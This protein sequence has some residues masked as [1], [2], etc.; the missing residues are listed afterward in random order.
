MS[1]VS[2]FPCFGGYFSEDCFDTAVEPVIRGLSVFNIYIP[3]V[4]Q[5]V[6]DV[7]GGLHQ[8]CGQNPTPDSRWR[9]PLG[10][11]RSASRW[12]RLMRRMCTRRPSLMVDMRL[13][14]TLHFVFGFG[15]CRFEECAEV[16]IFEA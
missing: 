4:P 16:V 15:D 3:N 12:Y 1:V 2:L 9:Y 6:D 13:L 7:A 10:V 5:L 11:S 14:V 8:R